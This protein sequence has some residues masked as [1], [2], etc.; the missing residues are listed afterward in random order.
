MAKGIIVVDVP[1]YCD[2]CPVGR[3][4]GFESAVECLVAPKD[5]C[6]SGYGFR[7]E[8]PDWCPIRPM[9][10]KKPLTGD[11]SNPEKVGNELVRAGW[12]ACIDEILKEVGE[13]E[14]SDN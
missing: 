4:C 8:K 10:E 2:Y 14:R 7:V 3:I 11:V 5:H 1:D 6:V 13:D 12:N 9:P